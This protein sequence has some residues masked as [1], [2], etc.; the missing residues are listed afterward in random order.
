M[1]PF[2]KGCLHCTYRMAPRQKNPDYIQWTNSIP[3]AILIEDL[4]RGIC[5]VEET[6]L[7]AEEAWEQCYSHMAEFKDVVFSQFEKR[8]K[9]HRRQIKKDLL[10]SQEEDWMMLHDREIFS[11]SLTN[12]RG[13]LVFD[14]HPAKVLLEADIKNKKHV[15]IEPMVLWQSRS[16]Y[17][18]FDKTIFRQ[19]IYQAIRREKFVNYLNA[20]RREGK[21]MRCKPPVYEE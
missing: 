19:R 3:K 9:D 11:R 10:R 12:E 1:L 14:L 15:G 4:V 5:P 20:K 16:E 6:E 21:L 7:T 2:E 8:L 18:M 17:K 13:N